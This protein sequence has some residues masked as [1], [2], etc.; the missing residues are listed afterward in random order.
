MGAFSSHS[1]VVKS[2]E[3]NQQY[4]NE[5]NKMKLERWIQMQAQMKQRERAQEIAKNREL[6]IWMSAF[7]LIA[8]SGIMSKFFRVKRPAVLSPLIPMSFVLLYYGDL[9][10]GTKLHRINLEAEMIMEHEKELLELPCNL[11]TVASIDSAR[12]ELDEESRL[13]PPHV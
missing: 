13:H 12:I 8:G 2:F 5:I 4:I 7:Y 11:P 10:Y 6:F 1:A 3:K 9:S